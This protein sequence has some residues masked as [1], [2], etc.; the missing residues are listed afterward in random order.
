[1][2]LGE[3]DTAGW[4]RPSLLTLNLKAAKARQMSLKRQAANHSFLL[5][6]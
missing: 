6:A 3:R 5:S 2:F 1:V 4:S